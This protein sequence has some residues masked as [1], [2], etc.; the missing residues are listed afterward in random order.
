MY[1]FNYKFT[2]VNFEQTPEDSEGQRSL[3]C[4]L[5]GVEKSW[6]WLSHWATTDNSLFLNSP[7]GLIFKTDIKWVRCLNTRCFALNRL[8]SAFSPVVTAHATLNRLQRSPSDPFVW[9][10]QK[11]ITAIHLIGVKTQPLILIQVH[12]LSSVNQLTT[13]NVKT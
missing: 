5:H 4:Y 8:Q 9:Q 6:I 2:T 1:T 11:K 10:I 7:I 13:C 3:G 12:C